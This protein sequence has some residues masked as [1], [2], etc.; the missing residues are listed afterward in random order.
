MKHKEQSY[1]WY[2]LPT[3]EIKNYVMIDG[4]NFVDQPVRNNLITYNNIQKV[5][6]GNEMI[7]RIVVC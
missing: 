5:A 2:F 3:R 7:I 4:Q 1:R 6:T